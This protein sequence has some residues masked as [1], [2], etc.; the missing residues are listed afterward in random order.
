MGPW[1]ITTLKI[2]FLCC[3]SLRC[4]PNGKHGLRDYHE[5]DSE[6]DS[7]TWG[8]VLNHTSEHLLSHCLT[9]VDINRAMGM[10]QTSASLWLFTVL[11]QYIHTR[12]SLASL[13]LMFNSVSIFPHPNHFVVA[14]YLFQKKQLE[15]PVTWMSVCIVVWCSSRASGHRGDTWCDNSSE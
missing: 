9:I 11:A 6:W 4:W 8:V 12:V 1:N 15:Y 13:T 10:L 3:R 7:F 5:I 2:H 14:R